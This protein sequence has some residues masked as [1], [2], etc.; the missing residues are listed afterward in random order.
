MALSSAVLS[1]DPASRTTT[2]STENGNLMC[3]AIENDWPEIKENS[4]ASVISEAND[5][6]ESMLDKAILNKNYV[7]Q[8]KDDELLPTNAIT[9]IFYLEY[10]ALDD[11]FNEFPINS[12][13]VVVGPKIGVFLPLENRYYDGSVDAISNEKSY[14]QV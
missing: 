9:D 1:F 7:C 2:V 12:R 11:D 10:G 3:A 13:N 14:C 5:E 6:L 4:F 8:K